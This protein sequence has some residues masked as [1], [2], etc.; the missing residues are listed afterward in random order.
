M[1]R[2]RSNNAVPTTVSS[3]S[4]TAGTS[5]TLAANTGWPAA[6]S[7]GSPKQGFIAVI[8]PGTGNQEVVYVRDRSVNSLTNII[9]NFDGNGAFTHANGSVITHEAVADDFTYPWVTDIAGTGFTGTSGTVHSGNVLVPQDCRLIRAVGA[10]NV[11][12]SQASGPVNTITVGGLTLTNVNAERY[13]KGTSGN[14]YRL[15]INAWL[16]NPAFSSFTGPT[17]QTLAW[18]VSGLDTSTTVTGN[19][20]VEMYV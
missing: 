6:S 9:R 14:T 18:S 8:E 19:L 1:G 2:N 5:A 4:G 11:P 7:T 20:L 16:V 10:L 12:S 3:L 13:N 17:N 15:P